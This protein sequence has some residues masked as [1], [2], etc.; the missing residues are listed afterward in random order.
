MQITGLLLLCKIF[1]DHNSAFSSAI[2]YF[3]YIEKWL[4]KL[5]SFFKVRVTNFVCSTIEK[6]IFFFLD[7][8]DNYF[9]GIINL[10]NLK[11]KLY[12]ITVLIGIKDTFDYENLKRA[13]TSHNL[14]GGVLAKKKFS[15]CSKFSNK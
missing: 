4:D 9:D 13:F 7:N 14:G 8:Y 15:L 2:F 5:K 6:S 11:R 3:F 1:D 12:L 10:D